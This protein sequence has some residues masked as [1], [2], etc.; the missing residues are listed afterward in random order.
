MVTWSKQAVERSV[1]ELNR[2]LE[3]RR[4]VTL[5]VVDVTVTLP[6]PDTATFYFGVGA[7]AALEL[8]EWPIALVIGV[9][10][11]LATRSRS[12][13]SRELGEAAESA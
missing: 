4:R 8:I 13:V 11:H 2:E 12:T 6:P 7:L 5:P 1:G 9:G 10:H 3:K